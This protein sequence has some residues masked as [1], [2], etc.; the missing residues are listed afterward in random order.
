MSK[1]AVRFLASSLGL[2]LSFIALSPAALADLPSALRESTNAYVRGDYRDAARILEAGLGAEREGSE[3][4]YALSALGTLYWLQGRYA[5]AEAALRRVAARTEAARGRDHPEVARELSRLGSVLRAQGRYRDAEAVYWRAIRVLEPQYGVDHAYVAECL[6]HL[7]ELSRLQRRHAEAESRYWRAYM[8]RTYLYGRDSSPVGE[9]M[10]GLAAVYRAQGRA[11]E[12][13]DLYARALKIAEKPPRNDHSWGRLDERDLRE[14]TPVERETIAVKGKIFSKEGS[15]RHLEFAQHYESLANLYRAHERF[16][17]AEVM[18][19]KA[20]AIR[21]RAFG[22]E[23][24]E[25]AQ[26]L[27]NVALL[28]KLQGNVDR[29]L[30]SVRVAARVL[31]RRIGTFERVEYAQGERRRWQ[32]VF[33]LELALLTAEPGGAKLTGEAFAAIQ[34][35]HL[36]SGTERPVSIAEAQKL[37]AHD[38]VLVATAGDEGEGYVAIVRKDR[39]EARRLAPAALPE[40]LARELAGSRALLVTPEPVADSAAA[41]QLPSVGS[42]RARARPQ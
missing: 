13:R 8:I 22:P 19:R 24:P 27:S 36:A 10:S 4:T 21:E 25:V 39:S 42:L 34:H 32:P 37:L 23:H 33:L 16:S 26:A 14:L 12:A 9:A 20:I 5:E 35:A 3:F 15:P 7:A 11:A 30:E 17:D 29:G 2:A 6:Y 31:A 1:G 41:V 40:L 28:H 38:E 18:F